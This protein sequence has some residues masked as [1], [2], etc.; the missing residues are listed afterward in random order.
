MYFD[1]FYGIVIVRQGK[2]MSTSDLKRGH[3]TQLF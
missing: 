2:I 1:T 3:A